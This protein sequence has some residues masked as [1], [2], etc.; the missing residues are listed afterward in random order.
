MNY[1]NPSRPVA[2]Q[3]QWTFQQAQAGLLTR[4]FLFTGIGFLAIFALSF[5]FYYLLPQDYSPQSADIAS[6]LI[7]LSPMLVFV[8]M[9]MGI[10]MRP[11]VTG[12]MGFIWATYA[13]FVLAQ[14]F[15]FGGLLYA[16]NFLNQQGVSGGVSLI[17]IVYIFVIAG[18]M[19]VGMAAVGKAMSR[20]AV[21]RFSRF[22]F[23]AVIVWLVASLILTMVYLFTFDP[24]ASRWIGIVVASVGSLIDLG[25]VVFIVGQIRRSSEFVDFAGNKTLLNS[26]AAVYG[27]WL[28]VNL[29]DLVRR[30]I[31]LLLQFRN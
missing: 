4:S 31:W 1:S 29:I 26:L 12:G 16:L 17:E 28:L 10:F 15:G 27:F 20:K 24:T 25:Y 5:G 14:S 18:L 6:T 8:S 21:V 2:A 23:A 13:I 30:L 11:K 7:Y 9:I 3:G 22:F 19:F